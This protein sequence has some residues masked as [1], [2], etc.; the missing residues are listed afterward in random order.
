MN[1]I[2]N[3]ERDR[4]VTLARQAMTLDDD[5][6]IVG[7]YTQTWK[8]FAAEHGISDE[9]A[10]SYVA[11][12]ARLKRGELVRAQGRPQIMAE[13]GPVTVYLSADELAMASR[14]GDGNVSAGVRKALA[15]ERQR[16]KANERNNEVSAA[17]V[18][19]LT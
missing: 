5:G 10:R 9:R 15:L 19:A 18:A 13:G 16:E 11:K 17:L 3:A 12:A 6:Q 2:T 14:L 4:L 1:R 8:V 7:N